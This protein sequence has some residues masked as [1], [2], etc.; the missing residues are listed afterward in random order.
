MNQ[1]AFNEWGLEVQPK[2]A[3]PPRQLP[4]ARFRPVAATGHMPFPGHRHMGEIG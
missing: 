1:P 2:P 3:P 4:A